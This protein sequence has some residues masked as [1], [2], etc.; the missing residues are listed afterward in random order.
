MK[1]L[2]IEWSSYGNDDLKKAMTDEGHELVIFPFCVRSS[3]YGRLID[4]LE[5]EERLCLLLHQSLPD[6]VYSTNFFP[7]ISKVCQKE[8]IHYISWNYD[9]PNM[10]LYSNLIANSCNIIYTFDKTECMKYRDMGFPHFH[11]LPLAV[12]TKRLDELAEDMIDKQLYVYDISFVGSLYLERMDYFNKIDL[13]LP[14]HTRGYLKGLIASQLQMRGYDLVEEMLPAIMEELQKV[15]SI[16]VQ[17]GL[18]VTSKAFYEHTIITPAITAIE[19]LDLLD[20]I[21]KHHIIDL[22]THAA[23]IS[24]TNVHVHGSVNYYKEMPL[25]FRQSKINLNITSRSIVSG[26]PLRVFDIMGA[27]G[28]LL[29]NFQ[30]DFLDLFVPDEDFVYYENKKDLLQ[31]IGYYLRHEE[32]RKAIAE[33][34]YAKIVAEHTYRHRVRELFQSL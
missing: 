18:L 32:E 26:V 16:V 22:F 5:M 20:A 28:F 10:L 13:L 6:V 17:P 23:D 9:A 30:A 2:F 21:A 1:I 15:C 8:G 31:K 3:T 14:D 25:V 27:G 29:S 33:N 19:R 11:Y 24:L 4:D 7:V 12:D 34:G